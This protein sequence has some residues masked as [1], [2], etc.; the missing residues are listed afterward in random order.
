MSIPFAELVQLVALVV[1]Q[2]TVVV[3]YA[4]ELDRYMAEGLAV[5]VMVGR[6]GLTVV[7]L[8]SSDVD[9]RVF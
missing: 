8:V 1:D 6:G 5:K 3:P 7:L 4:D 2:L 9:A